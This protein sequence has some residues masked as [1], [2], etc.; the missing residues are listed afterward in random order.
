[1]ADTCVRSSNESHGIIHTRAISSILSLRGTK[2]SNNMKNN[3]PIMIFLFTRLHLLRFH[4]RKDEIRR[5]K[6]LD[7]Q[8]VERFFPFKHET[9][10]VTVVSLILLKVVK[11]RGYGIIVS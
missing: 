6:D 8:K 7:E 11:R 2:W 5:R 3:S 9:L 1:M 10:S 4:M